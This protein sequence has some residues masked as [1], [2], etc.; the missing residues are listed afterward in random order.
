MLW[1]CYIYFIFITAAFLSWIPIDLSVHFQTPNY[2]SSYQFHFNDKDT[3]VR[4]S[5]FNIMFSILTK[6]HHLGKHS[7]HMVT[8][9]CLYCRYIFSSFS[10]FSVEPQI[11]NKI[12][13]TDSSPPPTINNQYT[14]VFIII[15]VVV[16]AI[17]VGA[18][19]IYLGIVSCSHNRQMMYE[20]QIFLSECV[21]IFSR[22]FLDFYTRFSTLSYHVNRFLFSLCFLSCRILVISKRK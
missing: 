4:N 2:T 9:H 19:C 18:C 16:A 14:F 11:T 10:I 7:Y 15:P 21:N 8:W 13:N 1:F 12:V 20:L 17:L 6:L 22:C 3:L 5:M